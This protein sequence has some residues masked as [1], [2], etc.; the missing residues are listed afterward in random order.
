[1][2]EIAITPNDC[3]SSTFI[4]QR[5]AKAPHL[6]ALGVGAVIS[7]DFFG[8]QAALIAGFDGLLIILAIVTVM[9]VL[10]TFSIAELSTTLP[11]GGGPYVFALHGIGRTA[12][13][14]A[15]L[16]ELLKVITTCAVVVVGIGSYW[17]QLL[18]LGDEYGP[19]WWVIVYALFAILNIMGVEL[20][21]RIQLVATLL[22]SSLLLIFYVGA[23]TKLD[24]HE[25]VVLQDWQF[26]DGLSGVLKGCS[27][28][29]WFY[30]GIE[31]LPLAIEETIEPTKNMPR[32]LMSS[33]ATLVVTSFCTVIFNSMISPG[34][35]IISLS[36]S[37]LLVGYKSVFG[38]N[39][40]TAG[41]TWLLIVGLLCSFHSFIFCMGRLL[42]AIAR[43]GYLPQ[44]LTKIHPTR[45]TPHVALICG[46]T[47]GLVTALLLHFIIGDVRLGS[48][49][50]NLA[51]IGA[52][53]SYAFQ[54]TAFILLR[55]RDPSRERP[56]R[57]CFGVPGALIC[58]ML[59]IL[60]LSSI[61]YNGINDM[62]FMASIIVGALVFAFGGAYYMI[63]V[64]PSH[65]GISS[66]KPF[67]DNLLS[68]SP[69]GI[70][71]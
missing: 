10:L 33:M 23:A 71:A 34:A 64:K 67:R 4:S 6:W 38:D 58:L 15:G 52:L 43:D 57:S 48:V 25:W 13:F 27:F 32:G 39:R 36:S 42:F 9:Y 31:E 37:P 69:S 24:Y 12:A 51:L 17:N 40:I 47:L 53:V 70:N 21:F 29:L 45:G 16:A 8:W 55:V 50:I 19:I 49:L 41:F 68:A 1:M 20:S 26:P 54:L 62:D 60:V 35:K 66:T 61:L 11:A 5:Y 30:L 59:C 28:A 44:I 2:T 63:R 46:S 56:Y 14:F 7:G 3:P 18:A 65:A 22:S